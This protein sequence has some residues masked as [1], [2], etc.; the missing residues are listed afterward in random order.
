MNSVLFNLLRLISIHD[1][2]DN[3]VGSLTE[4]QKSIVTGMLLGDGTL[5]GRK[6]KLLEVNHSYKQKEYV[7]WL[8]DEFREH[9]TLPP[10]IRVSGQNR[11]SCRFFTKSLEELNSYYKSFY[12]VKS[13]KSVPSTLQLNDLSLAVWFMDD[14]SSERKSI[15]FNTQQFALVDQELLLIKL[16]KIGLE[17]SL[18]KDKT[19]YRI[20]IFLKSMPRL[21]EMI[22]S[23][24]IK[25]M[26][27]KLP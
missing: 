23:H 10:K 3:T 25:S 22:D 13:Y 17:G 14:G 2:K 19:Y 21:K 8:Y 16:K 4:R 15:Y 24:V 18:N 27:Y 12:M 1:F 20:R 11:L 6:T 5:R 26:K 9:V 7:F